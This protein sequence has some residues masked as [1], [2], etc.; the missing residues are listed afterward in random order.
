MML[1]LG[2]PSLVPPFAFAGA[3]LALWL[4][5]GMARQGSRLPP[6]RLLLAGVAI[7]YMLGAVT[8]LLAVIGDPTVMRGI[9][10]WL[11]GGF[12][13][14][15]W[16]DLTLP[17]VSLILGG[18]YLMTEGRRLNALTLG[19]EASTTLG[20]DA[21][22]VRWRLLLLAAVMTG[23]C[24]AVSGAIGFV[25]LMVPHLVRRW[26]GADHRRLLPTVM[27]V[28]GVLLVVAD[29]VAR[30]AFLPRDLPVGILTALAGGPFF[31]TMMR[32]VRS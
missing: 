13:A 17:S 26:V 31:L 23:L 7:G 28:G 20:V 1:L 29:L 30:T 4:A 18:L 16:S 12:S 11:L 8:S 15:T 3:L 2:W 6:D 19:D 10:F 27:A 9:L 24:V 22:R 21:D 5:Q 14:A 32:R 25:G